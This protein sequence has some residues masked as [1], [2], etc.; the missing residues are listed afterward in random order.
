MLCAGGRRLVRMPSRA[1]PVPQ[2]SRSSDKT[3]DL[4]L[5]VVNWRCLEKKQI[6]GL[7]FKASAV[8]NHRDQQGPFDKTTWVISMLATSRDP[9]RRP[10]GQ[11]SAADRSDK[12]GWGLSISALSSGL[13]TSVLRTHPATTSAP[14]APPDACLPQVSLPLLPLVCRRPRR[15][16]LSVAL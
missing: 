6:P 10:R 2:G 15:W 13:P 1:T 4:S 9:V 3:S 8:A 16:R 5:R 11:G 12:D 7:K 14:P